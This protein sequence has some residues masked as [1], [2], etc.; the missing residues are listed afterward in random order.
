MKKKT[1][2]YDVKVQHDNTMSEEALRDLFAA[3]AMNAFINRYSKSTFIMFKN[4]AIDAYNASDA[5]IAERKKRS[6]L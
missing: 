3:H 1:D 4:L 2:K 5:M 6:K